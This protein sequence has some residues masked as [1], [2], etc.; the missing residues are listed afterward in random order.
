MPQ[1]KI[2]AEA[3]SNHANHFTIGFTR[4]RQTDKGEDAVSAGSGTLVTID[5]LHGILTAAHVLEA[6]PKH[7]D[8]GI[9]LTAE[10][11][12]HYQKLVI[13]MDHSEPPVVIKAEDFGPLGPDLAFLRITTEALG[14]LKA[15]NSFYSISKRRDDVLSSKPPTSSYVDCITGTIHELTNEEPSQRRGVRRVNFNTIFCPVRPSAV[16][17]FD[18]HDLLYVQTATEHEPA[19]KI[20]NSFEG[21][22]G[23]AVWR[24]YTAEK[25]GDPEIADAR[26]IGVPFHQSFAADGKVEIT[27]HGSKSIYGS[28]VG[29]IRARWPK[30]TSAND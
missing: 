29:L 2:S 16:R 11:P 24:F 18:T 13:K 1:K 6:L 7:E 3:L 19:F 26:L 10:S 21:T 22:S 14:W 27:C 5:S 28:L 8:V 30:E 17:Y 4:L 15:K 23:G 9:S 20:P 12:A 25:D